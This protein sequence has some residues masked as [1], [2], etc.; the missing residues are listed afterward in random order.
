MPTELSVHDFL[1]V[2]SEKESWALTLDMPS[3][4]YLL[5]CWTPGRIAPEMF[6]SPDLAEMNDLEFHVFMAGMQD[7]H[8]KS[9]V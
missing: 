2:M 4:K 8:T 7:I 9:D 1:A 6:Q 5:S 3:R